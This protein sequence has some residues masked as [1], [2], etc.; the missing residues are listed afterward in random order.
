MEFANKTDLVCITE[1][2]VRRV[3]RQHRGRPASGDASG[4]SGSP[5]IRCLGWIV[6]DAKT[7]RRMSVG[8]T[9]RPILFPK[10]TLVSH[11]FHYLVEGVPQDLATGSCGVSGGQKRS[12]EDVSSVAVFFVTHL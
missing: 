4:A 3:E 8:A 9:A 1:R 2:M 10:S 5:P 6:K 7:V 11:S 12:T